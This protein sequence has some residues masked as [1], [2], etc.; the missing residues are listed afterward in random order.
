MGDGGK[1]S[2]PRP[3]SV[4]HEKFS[5]QWETIFGKKNK[6]EDQEVL[7]TYNDERLK[8]KHDK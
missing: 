1:G 2:T 4:P 6:K 8:T 3:F 5:N 7:D